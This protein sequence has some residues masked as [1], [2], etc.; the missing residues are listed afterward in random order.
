MKSSRGTPPAGD[1]AQACACPAGCPRAGGACLNPRFPAFPS[2]LRPHSPALISGRLRR[3]PRLCFRARALSPFD[4][5]PSMSSM[6][7]RKR[8]PLRLS[9]KSR[10]SNTCLKHKFHIQSGQNRSQ[11]QRRISGRPQK[12]MCTDILRSTR[13]G[14]AHRRGLPNPFHE[15]IK[16]MALDPPVCRGQCVIGQYGKAVVAC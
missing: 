15:Y 9:W 10:P 13:K 3:T 5:L 14:I 4:L 8:K 2:R 1:N 11:E 7:S 12:L 16:T 6:H